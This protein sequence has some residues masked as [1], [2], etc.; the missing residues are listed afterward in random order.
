MFSSNSATNRYMK[1]TFAISVLLSTCAALAQAAPAA[2]EGLVLEVCMHQGESATTGMNEKPVDWKTANYSSLYL[3]F[4]GKCNNSFSYQLVESTEDAPW[5]P[6]VVTYLPE[7]SAITITGNDMHAEIKL[8]F[9]TDTSGTADF[10][11]HEEGSSLYIRGASFTMRPAS[12]AQG[13]VAMPQEEETD[14]AA[15]RVDDGLRQLVQE[16]E[17][18]EY[19][20]AVE[21]L[22]RKRLLTL[23]PQIMEGGDINNVLANANGTTAL[24]NAC[25]LSHVQIVQW[26]VDHGADL[27]AK[28]AKGASVD[29]CVGGPN[30]RAIRSIL[31]NA[32]RK[33]STHGERHVPTQTSF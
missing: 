18:T 14:G 29:D 24:H 31:R 1:T 16:L 21:R 11:W 22:Y 3:H 12:I 28:T 25:G 30:A 15:Q 9:N 33:T 2:L 5:P 32:R 17:Q 26:L 6:V 20:T 8:H 13:Y 10:V 19:K 4:P 7:S 27:N 23:L